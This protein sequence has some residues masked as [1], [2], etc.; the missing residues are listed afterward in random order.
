MATVSTYSTSPG[1]NATA[2]VGDSTHSSKLGQSTL[3]IEMP[4]TSF[5]N[6]ALVGAG[7]IQTYILRALINTKQANPI[8]ITRTAAANS[9][10]PDLSSVP[11]IEADY[12]NVPTLTALLKRHNIEIVVSTLSATASSMKAQRPLADEAK[13]SGIVKLFVPSEW[14]LA[15]EGW[16][17]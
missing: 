8:V 1:P 13:A 2:S 4:S 11:I 7:G 9:L 16:A 17:R 3:S 10:P 14:G 15:S 5:K 6:I 12:T